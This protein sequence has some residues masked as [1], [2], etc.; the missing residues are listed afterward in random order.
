MLFRASCAFWIHPSCSFLG[1]KALKLHRTRREKGRTRTL[2]LEKE[3]CHEGN[4]YGGWIQTHLSLSLLSYVQEE[5][6]EENQTYYFLVVEERARKRDRATVVNVA[7]SCNAS[8]EC[9][10]ILKAS[11]SLTIR[12]R[13]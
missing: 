11:H 10:T 5:K 4:I 12:I 1:S 6:G 3:N 9:T 2:H 8:I 13:K 7:L